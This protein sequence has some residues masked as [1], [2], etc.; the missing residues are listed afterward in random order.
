MARHPPSLFL[1][2]LPA[3]LY[4]STLQR[5]QTPS[6]SDA[7][8]IRRRLSKDDL[9]THNSSVVVVGDVPEGCTIV[10]AGDVVVLGW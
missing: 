8:Y 6:S 10:S 1:C 5:E 7:A 2:L 9:I 3:Q 4:A